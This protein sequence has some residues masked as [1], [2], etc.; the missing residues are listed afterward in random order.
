MR[1]VSWP[2]N[3]SALT[4]RAELLLFN[5]ANGRVIDAPPDPHSDTY[6]HAYLHQETY[7]T[8]QYV[9]RLVGT[10]EQ[11][12]FPAATHLRHSFT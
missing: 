9:G 8:S 3:S 11:P 7:T 5:D 12:A 1:L 6:M 10:S 4:P 2:R